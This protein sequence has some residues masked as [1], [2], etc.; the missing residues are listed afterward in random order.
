VKLYDIS[1][2][3]FACAVYPGDPKPE[4]RS[5]CSMEAGDLY[6]LTEFSMCAH[7]G[8]HVDAPR[9]FYREGK[10]VGQLSL[11]KFI[12][13]AFVACH[14]G[15]VT[16]GDARALLD[17]AAAAGGEAWRKL[18]IRGAATVTPAAARVFAAAGVDLIGNESQSVGPEEAPMEVHLILLGAE[19]VLLEG[20]RLSAVPEGA[21]LLNCAPLDLGEAEGAPCRA[22]LLELPGEMG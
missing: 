14:E 17:R 16:E 11:E 1:Q 9:H 21:Y 5:L 7:N 20:I 8:T 10:G 4:K 22:L 6:N 15:E 19:V 13:P 2:P 18:L 3:V 12:G